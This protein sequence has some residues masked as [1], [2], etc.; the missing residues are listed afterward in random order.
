MFV[1]LRLT[2]GAVPVPLDVTICGLLEAL[3]LILNEAL[4]LPVADGVKATVTVHIPLGIMVAAVQESI[5]LLK[6]LGFV[7]PMAT[8]ETVRLAVPVLLRVSASAALVVPTA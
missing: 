5:T 1:A 8:V 6:S 7:P 2:V 4:R 3:S